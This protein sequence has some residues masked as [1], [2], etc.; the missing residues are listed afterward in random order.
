MSF[1]VKKVKLVVMVP[2]DY[3]KRVREVVLDMGAGVIGNYTHCST[4]F[5]GIGSFKPNEEANP[6]IG[7]NNKIEYVEEA[8]LEI[9][10]NVADVKQILKAIRKIHPYEEPGIDIIPLLDEDDFE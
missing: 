7:E 5:L 3:L 2:C 9:M 4:S 6:F 10:V 8:R 1:D